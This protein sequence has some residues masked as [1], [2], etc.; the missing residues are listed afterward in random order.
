MNP[1]Q[2]PVTAGDLL[3][4]IK[5]L[6]PRWEAS[7]KKQ[8]TP[9]TG[10]PPSVKPLTIHPSVNP[11]L[12]RGLIAACEYIAD[13]RDEFNMT[14]VNFHP[15]DLKPGKDQGCVICHAERLS[16]W[17][18]PETWINLW[19][20]DPIPLG[21]WMRIFRPDRWSDVNSQWRLGYE[22]N[23]TL[24]ARVTHFLETGE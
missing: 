15:D 2:P 20:M 7:V 12:A 8:A 21:H 13:H 3:T 5:N 16:N 14:H 22:K 10:T 17:V 19:N 23:E 18:R 4:T 9:R 11:E 6:D 1:S 24:F